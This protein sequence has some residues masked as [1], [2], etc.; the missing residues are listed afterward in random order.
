[1]KFEPMSYKLLFAD[2]PARKGELQDRYGGSVVAD[3]ERRSG[4]RRQLLQLSLRDR[5]DLRDGR[6]DIG[7]RLEENLDHRDT[8]HRLRFD[9]LDV[10]DGGGERALG[11][12]DDALRHV[13]RGQARVLPDDAHHRNVDVRENSVGVRE[14]TTG[15]RMNSIKDKTTNVYGRRNARRTIHIVDSWSYWTLPVFLDD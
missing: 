13:L 9:V 12:V 7:V 1:M 10:V 14:I 2:A 3:D 4:A 6:A 5:R 8:V 11:D 15:A